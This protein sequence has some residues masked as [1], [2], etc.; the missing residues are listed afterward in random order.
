MASYSL[1]KIACESFAEGSKLISGLVDVA[2]GYGSPQITDFLTSLS[3][4]LGL[5]LSIYA[6][7]ISQFPALKMPGC[8]IFNYG[9][10]R[11]SLWSAAWWREALVDIRQSLR[12]RETKV[13]VLTHVD[14]LTFLDSKDLGSDTTVV[15][16]CLE[17]TEHSANFKLLQASSLANRVNHWIFPERERA[18]HEAGLWQV[19]ESKINLCLNV[20]KTISAPT[21]PDKTARMIYA[22]SL[23]IKA[24][25]GQKL[26]LPE[27]MKFPIDIYGEVQGGAE[28]AELEAALADHT[29]ERRFLGGVSRKDLLG[30]LPRY[31]FSIVFWEPV[32]PAF[33]NAC[34]NKFFEALSAGVPVIA[35]P[36]PQCVEL[37]NRYQC[38]V[39]LR[40]WS[41]QAWIEGLAR[42][43]A[44]MRTS[45]YQK[46]VDGCHRAVSKELNWE[47]Q[48]GPVINKVVE[49]VRRA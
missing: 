16:L 38:G 47:A 7:S 25:A 17:P 3:D 9:S 22:G 42:A 15:F 27:S 11:L 35:A 37:I 6:P 43:A 36:H 28:V 4:E 10:S 20:S 14:F 40:D 2:P 24:T 18:V 21:H 31:S 44:L 19:P 33:L 12:L 13:L 49:N 39:L 23:D 34:P 32:T 45:D 26:A 48:Y 8:Q 29:G 1:R 30:R 41:S 5:P 46:L